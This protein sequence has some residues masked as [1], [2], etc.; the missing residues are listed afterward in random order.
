MNMKLSEIKAMFV[1]GQ[2]WTV[3]REG[4]KP[5]PVHG[6]TGVSFL[7]AHQIQRTMKPPKDCPKLTKLADACHDGACNVGALLR[8]LS[9]A[10]NELEPG[11]VARHPA[12][13]M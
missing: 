9:G 10:V 7:G 5:L 12:I 13:K 6:N 8:A 3:T 1:P 4:G 2:K 11:T